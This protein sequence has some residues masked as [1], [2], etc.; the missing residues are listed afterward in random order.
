MMSVK[1]NLK[2]T[3]TSVLYGLFFREA[4]EESVLVLGYWL[5]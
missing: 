5:T 3:G 2:M 1:S 4:E